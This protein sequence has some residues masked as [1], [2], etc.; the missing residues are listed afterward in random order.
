MQ[1]SPD[2][3]VADATVLAVSVTL[4]GLSGD[5]LELGAVGLRIAGFEYVPVGGAMRCVPDPGAGPET[6]SARSGLRPDL[7]RGRPPAAIALAFLDAYLARPPYLVA[8]HGPV[9]GQMIAAHRDICPVLA[10]LT[11]L[12][13]ERLVRQLFPGQDPHLDAWADRLDTSGLTDRVDGRTRLTAALVMRT[14]SEALR[15]GGQA[16]LVSLIHS[17]QPEQSTRRSAPRSASGPATGE[18]GRRLAWTRA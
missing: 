5:L 11:I 17:A 7:V 15:R 18:R 13:T 16:D 4:P 14:M 3:N 8:T 12:D 10:E 9:L 2:L 6:T 1:L